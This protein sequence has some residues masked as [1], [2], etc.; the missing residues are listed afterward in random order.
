MTKEKSM[1]KLLISANKS[2]IQSSMTDDKSM[3]QQPRVNICVSTTQLR[4]DLLSVIRRPCLMSCIA[5]NRKRA[6]V[7]NIDML[8][9]NVSKKLK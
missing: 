9:D 6:P 5:A 7:P 8:A 4:L 1:T 3:I 2:M